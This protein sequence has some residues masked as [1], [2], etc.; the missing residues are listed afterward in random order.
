MS[1]PK[2]H[3]LCV[4]ATFVTCQVWHHCQDAN[5]SIWSSFFV[6]FPRDVTP[7]GQHLPRVRAGTGHSLGDSTASGVL[8][9]QNQGKTSGSLQECTAASLSCPETIPCVRDLSQQSKRM[10]KSLLIG[11]LCLDLPFQGELSLSQGRAESNSNF[12]PHQLHSLWN[13][14]ELLFPEPGTLWHHSQTFL[15]FS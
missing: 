10:G 9:R 2:G 1:P 7:Q 14:P 15:G 12:C 11:S 5:R 3:T 13:S 8:S 6:A 4:S